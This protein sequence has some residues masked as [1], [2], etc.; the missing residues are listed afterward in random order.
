MNL[1][2]GTSKTIL[3]VAGI[4]CLVFGILG[5]IG[6]I[7]LIV[8][9]CGANMLTGAA[10]S[11][12]TPEEAAELAE[13]GGA[14]M[15]GGLT[16]GIMIGGF[17][18]LISSAITII[19]GIFSLRAAKDS[20]KATPAFIF[21]IIGLVGSVISMI[22]SLMNGFNFTNLLSG[23]VSVAISVLIFMAAKTVRDSAN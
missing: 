17:V 14:E 16:A 19:E 9:G 22:G 21:A 7:M 15:V 5:V 10:L 4:L 18:A 11:Q 12:M 13:I 8:G 2:L 23:L 1:S 20:T 6:G 3:K